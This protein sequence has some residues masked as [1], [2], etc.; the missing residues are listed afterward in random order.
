[1][2]TDIAVVGILMAAG[3]LGM[4]FGHDE[5]GG[6]KLLQTLAFTTL[7]LFQLVNTLNARSNRQ[8]AFTGLFRNGWLWSALLGT[9]A[10]QVFVLNLPVLE[11]ALSV[12]PLSPGQWARSILVAS[13]VLWAMEGVKWYRRLR[14]STESAQVS[15]QAER[16]RA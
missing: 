4:F 3:S 8:S 9:F 7:I 10:L 5:G 16:E 12:V 15:A 2:V 1:M 14:A 13:S 6:I 11:Q